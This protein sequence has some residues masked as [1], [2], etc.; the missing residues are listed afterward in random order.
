ME[1]H[2]PGDLHV[3]PLDDL[4]EHEPS[5]ECWCNPQQDEEMPVLWV[6]NSLDG[7]EKHERGAPL[8]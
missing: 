8:H 3:L 6:H 7:R 1:P 5:R 2:R 4:R